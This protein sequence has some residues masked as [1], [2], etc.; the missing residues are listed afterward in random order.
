MSGVRQIL[1]GFL[2]P[3]WLRTVNSCEV[4]TPWLIHVLRFAFL[5]F[6]GLKG[7]QGFLYSRI[8][9]STTMNDL[10]TITFTYV[11]NKRKINTVLYHAA[12]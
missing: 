11:I 4:N 7:E 1:Y 8:T 2:Y 12:K 5:P 6:S 9:N 10:S 3:F